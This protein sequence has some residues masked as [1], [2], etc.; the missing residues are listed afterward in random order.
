[1]GGLSG[2]MHS[3][4][5]A[6]LQQT[7]TYFVVAHFHYVL[8]GGSIFA[9]IGRRLLLVAQDVR[10]HAGRG[11]GQ[12]PL[13]AD[14]HRVQ[15]HLLPD[16]HRRA[17]GHAAPGVHLPGRARLRVAQP[18][19]DDRR[20]DP[21][22]LVPRVHLST[23]IRVDARRCMRR[24][25]RGTAPRSSGRSRRPRRSTTSP[26]IPTVHGRDPFWDEKRA[27]GGKVPEP[28]RVSGAGIHLPEPVLLAVPGG[29]GRAAAVH[30]A[31]AH[32]ASSA[33]VHLRG[34]LGALLQHFQLGLRTGRRLRTNT[35]GDAPRA[36]SRNVNRHPQPEAGDLDLHRVRVPVLRVADLG[37]P[38]LQGQEPG[39]AV[40]LGDLRDPAG[41]GR[42]R[43]LLLFSSLFVVL[44]L[45]G[46]EQGNRKKCSSAVAGA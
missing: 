8:F 45:N 12:A 34:G 4:A 27:H 10:A 28:A 11:A 13:L 25:I 14:V 33:R 7:D 29:G 35:C 36:A 2:V 43:R 44:A 32:E 39:G 37:L 40:S 26:S 5:P 15:P 30:R 3:T 42:A 38:G 23:C 46:C 20:A 17:R 1:M 21:R 18:A 6:D 22:L 31:A 24:P 16:A 41:H 19:R 9:L